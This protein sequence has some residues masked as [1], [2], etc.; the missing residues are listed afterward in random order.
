MSLLRLAGVTFDGPAEIYG[1]QLISFPE[2]L[3]IGSGAFIN[4]ECVF[5]SQGG[6]T[7]GANTLVGPRVQFLT[8]NHRVGDDSH[9][10]LKPVMVGSGV[11]IGAGATI[12]PGVSIGEGAIVGAGSVVT[13]DVP[14]RARVAG[15][16][17]RPIRTG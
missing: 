16:P 10:E 1:S 3:R 12:V 15:V 6:I 8:S 9:D 7:L 14:A 5:E 4:S 17:A 2:N 13:K 11:W